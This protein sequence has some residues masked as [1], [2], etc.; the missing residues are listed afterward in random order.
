MSIIMT[1]PKMA[2]EGYTQILSKSK[3]DF[4]ICKALSIVIRRHEAIVK[5]LQRHAHYCNDAHT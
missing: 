1:P 2:N 4:I 3:V 5:L